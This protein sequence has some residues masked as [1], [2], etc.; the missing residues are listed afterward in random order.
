MRVM[1]VLVEDVDYW[2]T[3]EPMT[4]STLIAAHKEKLQTKFVNLVQLRVPSTGVRFEDK[5]DEV[6]VSLGIAMREAVEAFVGKV[7]GMNDPVDEKDSL[8][9]MNRKEG[10]NSALSDIQA[11]A[12]EFLK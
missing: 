2:P 3:H 6:G 1:A 10:Y 5:M 7:E 9:E 4:L 12:Q 8:A 11:K